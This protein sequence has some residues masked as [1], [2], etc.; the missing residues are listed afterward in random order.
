MKKL[1][2][3]IPDFSMDFF[4]TELKKRKDEIDE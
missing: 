3:L 2:E 4:S 1:D